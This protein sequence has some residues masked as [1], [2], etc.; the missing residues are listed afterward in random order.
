MENKMKEIR[1]KINDLLAVRESKNKELK[2]KETALLLAGKEL[3]NAQETLLILQNVAQ[4]TQQQLESRISELVTT[5]LSIFPDPYE[6]KLTYEM[7]RNKTE[8]EIWFTRDGHSLQ[9]LDS[10]GY[11]TID[12]GGFALRVALWS[13][14]P[15]RYDNVIWMDEPFKNIND[16]TRELHLK[17][18]RMVKQIADKL[19]IQFIVVSQ[20]PEFE[21]VADKI[22]EVTKSKGAPIVTEL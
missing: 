6:L 21:E 3:T 1:K 13:I 20:I 17:A 15:N 5:A 2:R 14:R 8:A 19:K 11:G 4:K 12:V 10:S 22:F 7:K 18:V 9:P 16:K